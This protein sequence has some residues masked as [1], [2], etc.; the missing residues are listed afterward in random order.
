MNILLVKQNMS[1]S[2]DDELQVRI[3]LFREKYLKCAYLFSGQL[4]NLSIQFSL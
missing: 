3:P 4:L 2:F 1:A